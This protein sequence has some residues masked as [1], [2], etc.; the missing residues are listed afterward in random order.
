MI[1]A[2]TISDSVLKC[3]MPDDSEREIVLQ[4]P[5]DQGNGFTVIR[6][7]IQIRPPFRDANLKRQPGV[8]RFEYQF[9]YSYEYHTMRDLDVALA[10]KRLIFK[11]PVYAWKDDS[12]Y[13][14]F[15]VLLDED[16]LNQ[17]N[18]EGKD[19]WQIADNEKDANPFPNGSQTLTF[20][21]QDALKWD[22]FLDQLPWGNYETVFFDDDGQPA[23]GFI[24]DSEDENNI[25]SVGTLDPSEFGE[26]DSVIW[27][28]DGQSF[29]MN[30]IEF[31][32]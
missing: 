12:F 25:L 18:F 1:E 4:Q 22:D 24:I 29:E 9:V 5:T 8:F 6:R 30:T 26:E 17:N 32:I 28:I 16:E 13:K 27:E 23:P 14:E 15:E 20:I 10:S 31:K 3:I 19:I 7:R 2:Y 11:A 21:L